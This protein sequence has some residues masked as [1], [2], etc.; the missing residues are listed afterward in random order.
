[1][2]REGWSAGGAAVGSPILTLAGF[3][4]GL[5][6]TLAGSE[7][8]VRGLTRLGTKLG[9]S[10]GLLGLLAAL[11]ADSP[12]LSSAVAAIL[13][14]AGNV[15]VGVVVGSNLFNLAA[16]LGLSAMLAGGVRI[17]RG[18]LILDAAV[19]LAV[20]ACAALMVGGIASPMLA[21]GLVVPITAVYV[22]V[23]AVPRRRL[24]RFRPLLRGVPQNVVEIAYD[25]TH[26]RPTAT[27]GS[28]VPVF[29]LPVAIAC[30]VGGAFVMVHEALAAQTWLRLS[31]G[32][33]GTLVLAALT[34]LPNLWVA[35]H[36]ARTDR[37][38]ALF[39]S[40]MNS[41]TINL[42]GGLIVPAVFVGIG[43]ARGSLPYFTWLI[44][45]TLLAVLAPLPHSKLSRVAGGVIICIYLV[46]VAVKLAGV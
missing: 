23:L 32:V 1:V 39:S 40:A 34:S 18:P 29:F 35:L 12:E 31:P 8:L 41:N 45:L 27:H 24:R 46:F 17:R 20:I 11:G 33:L 6:V 28:W 7:V 25:V 43:A 13:A 2:C 42:V 30:V 26:D 3:V 21:V 5:A 9:F 37:G 14:G 19:G 15:G 38:T 4:A 36:F 16:L 10:E 44:E 22:L